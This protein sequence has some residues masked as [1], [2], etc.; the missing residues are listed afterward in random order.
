M[1]IAIKASHK[2]FCKIRGCSELRVRGYKYC[3]KHLGEQYAK[4]VMKRIGMNK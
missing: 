2:P 1:I 4:D 3:P